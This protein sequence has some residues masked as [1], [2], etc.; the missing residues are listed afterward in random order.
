MTQSAMFAAAKGCVPALESPSR[1]TRGSHVVGL[2]RK[3]RPGSN[4]FSTADADFCRGSFPL[5]SSINF[6]VEMA[7]SR[8]HVEGIFRSREKARYVKAQ[9]T[10]W[11]FLRG[12]LLFS[13]FPCSSNYRKS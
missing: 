2:I 13:S 7:R 10:G 11:F 8:S 1:R 12:L 3:T 6:G 4:R 9:A 5:R